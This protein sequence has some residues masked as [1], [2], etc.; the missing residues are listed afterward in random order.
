MSLNFFI[1]PPRKGHASWRVVAYTESASG[2]KY[3]PSTDERVQDIQERVRALNQMSADLSPTE[4]RMR[5]EDL[6]RERRRQSED[7]KI[8]L[9]ASVLNDGN[10]RVFDR[11]WKE[12][13]SLRENKDLPAARYEFMRALRRLGDLSLEAS[14][15]EDIFV[16]LRDNSP[17][18][19]QR[20]KA[21]SRINEI[22]RFLGRKTLQPGKKR[23]E[24]DKVVIK[25]L[26]FSDVMKLA[27]AQESEIAKHAVIGLF[28]TGC[29]IGEFLAITP[30]RLSHG[31]VSVE[32]Q[33]RAGKR[34]LHGK[35]DE[36]KW[37]RTGWVV[38]IPQCLEALERW[39][40]IEKN[41]GMGKQIWKWITESSRK[42]WPNQPTKHITTHDLRHSHAIYLLEQGASLEDVAKNLRNSI[43]VCQRYYSGYAHTEGTRSRLNRILSP[44][45]HDNC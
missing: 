13:Y 20:K 2:R 5:L 30:D 42:L 11:F 19:S 43:E 37:G 1:Q 15:L 18:L 9:R 26:S 40:E 28:G 12:R 10:Q 44:Q 21:T 36:P 31:S 34:G 3:I 17:S 33:M 24:S 35:L 25:Y 6:I 4:I 29:R 23:K 7:L 38:V 39:A 8:R 22:L 27:Q 32:V 16:A 14:K 41:A 45:D